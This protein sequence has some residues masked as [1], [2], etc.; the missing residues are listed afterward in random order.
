[1]S[2]KKIIAPIQ[3]IET[4]EGALKTAIAIARRHKAHIDALHIRQRPNVPAGG[5]YPVGVVFVDEHLAE[6]KEM[7]EAEASKLKEI[8][9]RVMSAEGVRTVAAAAHRDES[10]A[11]ASWRDQQGILPFDLSAAARV[12]DLVV[13]GR[14]DG[15]ISYPDA[16]LIE[17]AIFQSGRPV[18]IAPV[19]K[20]ERTP[21]RILVAWNGGREAARALSSAMPLFEET[22]AALVLSIGALPS[23]LEGPEKAA[24]LLR[25]HGVKAE[26]LRRAATDGGASEEELLA[27]A[28]DWK[29]DLIVMGAYSHSRWRELVLGGFTRKLLKQ[30]EFPL[31]LA[32]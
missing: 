6:F 9:D 19:G 1:M 14:R 28:R 31:F 25:L 4:A 24:E 30:S 12:C 8:F 11:T 16:N 32:H 29:A 27:A 5:Y 18:L 23:D 10:G 3:N 20:L 13:F 2:V 15:E 21:R 22:D 17:E 7:L 26:A